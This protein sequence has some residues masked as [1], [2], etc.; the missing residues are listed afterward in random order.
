[1][2]EPWVSW[3][4]NDSARSVYFNS[5]NMFLSGLA[6]LIVEMLE[7]VILGR[8]YIGIGGG[9]VGKEESTK[10]N[11]RDMLIPTDPRRPRRRYPVRQC[12]Y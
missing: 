11:R 8:I 7:A 9:S 2:R 10:G 5:E 12:R 6:W 1:M 4:S 3:C